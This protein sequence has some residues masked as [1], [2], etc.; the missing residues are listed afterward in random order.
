[1]KFGEIQDVIQSSN[2]V[3]YLQAKGLLASQSTANPARTFFST[4]SPLDEPSSNVPSCPDWKAYISTRTSKLANIDTGLAGHLLFMRSS[5]GSPLGLSPS[6]PHLPN[7]NI[8]ALHST[9]SNT[10]GVSGN[11][12]AA[13]TQRHPL[14]LFVSTYSLMSTAALILS[15]VDVRLKSRSIV[16]MAD[17][18]ICINRDSRSS[19]GPADSSI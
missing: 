5:S 10:A 11:G 6:D 4:L 13:I 9:D 12:R 7:S 16:A 18:Y 17:L 1:M 3:Q 14:E 19:P 15:I 8:D 2:L